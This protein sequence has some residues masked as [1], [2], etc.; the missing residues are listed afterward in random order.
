[1][2]GWISNARLERKE[3]VWNL[4]LKLEDFDYYTLAQDLD[5][6]GFET[7]N[8]KTKGMGNNKISINN[9]R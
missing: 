2:I 7:N 8:K 1:M 6:V 9:V 5:N 3:T 4:I